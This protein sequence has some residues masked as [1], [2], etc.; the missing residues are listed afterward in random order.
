MGRRALFAILALTL[1]VPALLA[2]R[3]P[4]AEAQWTPQSCQYDAGAWP[5]YGYALSNGGLMNGQGCAIWSTTGLSWQIWGSTLLNQTSAWIWTYVEGQDSCGGGVYQS[6]MS[7]SDT[8]TNASSGSSGPWAPGPFLDCGPY[9]SGHSY[10]IIT[11]HQRQ[12][13]PGWPTEGYASAV[14]F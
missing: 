2:Q 13:Y 4:V 14:Y 12:L 5:T 8:A 6:D 3:P 10:R 7:S 9:S 1:A 11:Q